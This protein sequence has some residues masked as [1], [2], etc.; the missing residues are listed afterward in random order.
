MTDSRW[1]DEWMRAWRSFPGAAQTDPWSNPSSNPWAA[2]LDHFTKTNQAVY[3]QPL[4]EAV[5]KLTEQSRAFFELGQQVA[6]NDQDGWQQSVL[7]YLDS[8]CEQLTD[9]QAAARA[10]TGASPLDYWR[11]FAGH[12][13]ASPPEAH[14]FM[15]Q[16]EKTLQTPGVGY[17]REHQESM[18][19]LSRRWLS[20]EKAHGE[21][22]A[23]CAETARRSAEK[24]RHRLKEAFEKD[25]GPSSIRALYDAWVACSEEVYAE[26]TGTREYMQLHGR[27]VNALMAYKQQAARITDQWAEALGLPTREEIDALHRKLKDTRQALRTLETTAAKTPGK[28]ATKQV[29]KQTGKQTKKKT[30]KKRARK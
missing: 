25:R 14:S 9:P 18:Q 12:D 2:A 13:A 6:G 22:A 19:E 11:Q 27:M 21:Y 30:K 5:N 29:K 7:K 26:R 20:Y 4:A 10:L 15:S 3:Q 28:Q 16:V 24:L 1:F 23:Y 8:L 17:T